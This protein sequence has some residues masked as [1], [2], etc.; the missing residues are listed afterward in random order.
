MRHS[1]KQEADRGDRASSHCA[2]LTLGSVASGPWCDHCWHELAMETTA[3][4]ESIKGPE[5]SSVPHVPDVRTLDLE[6]GE[7][8]DKEIRRLL[9]IYNVLISFNCRVQQT[10]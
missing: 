10:N 1:L 8:G 5:C 6:G 7:T 9:C 2:H 3:T 4:E